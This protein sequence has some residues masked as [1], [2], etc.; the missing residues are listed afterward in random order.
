MHTNINDGTVQEDGTIAS[1]LT[2]SEEEWQHTI[3]DCVIGV[4]DTIEEGAVHTL[5]KRTEAKTR[6]LIEVEAPNLEVLET[7]IAVLG[8]ESNMLSFGWT[9]ADQGF[10]GGADGFYYDL[11]GVRYR[12]LG[13]EGQYTFKQVTSI[14]QGG[15]D[16]DHIPFPLVDAMVMRALNYVSADIL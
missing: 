1:V 6:V 9:M 14:L 7:I 12:R 8:T 16:D 15:L 2:V 5:S 11:E 4:V 13:E 10:T 3:P